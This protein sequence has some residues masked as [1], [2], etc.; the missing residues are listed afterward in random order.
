MPSQ[1][2]NG[3]RRGPWGGG[4]LSRPLSLSICE[5]RATSAAPNRTRRRRRSVPAALSYGVVVR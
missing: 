1:N 4:K 2:D 3:G 5:S